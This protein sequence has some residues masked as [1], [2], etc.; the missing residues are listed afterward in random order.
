MSDKEGQPSGE[1]PEK[2]EGSEVEDSNQ[3][4]SAF[5]EARK[6]IDELK[7]EISGLDKK[8]ADLLKEKTER[9]KEDKKRLK[10][11]EMSPK[12]LEA[13]L[14]KE[15]AEQIAEANRQAEEARAQLDKLTKEVESK[16]ILNKTINAKGNIPNVIRRLLVEE[17]P[18]DPDMLSDYIDE[19]VR[20]YE[21][22]QVMTTNRLKVGV[23]PQS[24]SK[25][26]AD[27]MPPDRDWNSLT[28]I[29]KEKIARSLPKEKLDA[30]LKK[31]AEK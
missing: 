16:R 24:G 13:F 2:G 19:V 8:N 14:A 25:V 7:K 20:D 23:R 4:K 15:S 10:Q 3:F 9:E 28:D 17:R 29:D 6:Q 26:M 22:E 21:T 30:I 11:K 1:I 27:V 18:E 31:D 5:D 12:E